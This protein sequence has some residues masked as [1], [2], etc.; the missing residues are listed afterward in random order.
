[1]RSSRYVFCSFQASNSDVTVIAFMIFPAKTNNFNVDALQGQA[2]VKQLRY[3]AGTIL[4]CYFGYPNG[5][6]LDSSGDI[7]TFL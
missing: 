6:Y 2:H 1:M 4:F 7:D 5:P 3:V